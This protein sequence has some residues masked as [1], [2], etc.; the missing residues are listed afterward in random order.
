MRELCSTALQSLCHAARGGIGPCRKS[1][2]AGDAAD[3]Q[4]AL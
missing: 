4:T 2:A 1:L 3:G